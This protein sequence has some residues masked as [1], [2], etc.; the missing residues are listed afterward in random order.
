MITE[1][2]KIFGANLVCV[3]EY[4]KDQQYVIVLEKITAQ[5]LNESKS[6]LQNY[7]KKIKKFPLLLTHEE[8]KDGLDVFPLEFLNIKLNHKILYGK[9]IF[10][11]LKFEEKHVRRELEYE[12]RSK[13]ISLR[14]SYLVV[15]SDK[16][17]K[18]IVEK[19][20]PTLLPMLNGLLFLKNKTIPDNITEILDVTEKEYG[21]N[22][23][24]LKKIR[25]FGYSNR[26]E[27]IRELVDL[28]S[29]LGE[30][31]NSMKV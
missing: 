11:N 30:I 8:L 29:K 25:D 4:G 1:I 2:Q 12:F 31:L 15:K 19:S 16:E 27:V 24:I 21:V 23:S 26:E 14:Q 13:L 22:I 17:L 20:I 6:L 10:K 5:T 3:A 18:L 9:D 28:L 7:F